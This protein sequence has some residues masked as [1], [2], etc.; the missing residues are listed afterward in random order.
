[1]LCMKYISPS[2]SV[3]P[4]PALLFLVSL[5][6]LVSSCPSPCQCK[7]LDGWNTLDCF[8]K[9]ITKLPSASDNIAAIILDKNDLSGLES[10]EFINAGLAHVRKIS[11]KFTNLS[12]IDED[13]FSG[14]NNLHELDLSHNSL[15]SLSRHQFPE[16][17]ELR[18]LDVSHNSLR[19]IHKD[20]FANLGV[21]VERI[22]LANNH[23]ISVP[24]TTFIPLTN[25][26]QLSL[27]DNP[28]HCDCKLGDLHSDLTH[29]N[30]IPDKATCTTPRTLFGRYWS[31]FHPSEFTCQPSVSLPHP[32]H[33][34]VQAGQLVPLHC[35]VKGNPTPTVTWKQDGS[36]LPRGSYDTYS[37]RQ[38]K[39][40]NGH[41][42]VI[43]SV[44]TIMNMSSLSLG[45]YSCLA[46]NSVGLE[47][48]D[49]NILFLDSTEGYAESENGQVILTIAICASLT[50]TTIITLT[51][52]LVCCIIRRKGI[53]SSSH[54][55]SFTTLEY[56]KKPA[57]DHDDFK[58]TWTNP[59]PKPPR[60]GA[61]DRMSCEDI[62][63]TLSRSSTRQTY[64]ASD[65]EYPDGDTSHLTG[66]G[67]EEATLPRGETGWTRCGHPP[68]L[69][70]DDS[71]TRDLFTPLSNRP[72]SR[73][74]VGTISTFDPIYGTVR[75]TLPPQY[76]HS[77][78]HP[79]QAI[80]L[81]CH[82]RP[83]Y[84]TLPRIPKSSQ[85]PALPLDYLGP[86]SSADG[87]SHSSISTLPLNKSTYHQ[88]NS[89]I[90]PPYSPPPP[91]T[92]IAINTIGLPSVEKSSSE[93]DYPTRT[94]TPQTHAAREGLLDTIPEQE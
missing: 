64:L 42:T 66:D 85:R 35:Q 71:Y 45:R 20:S 62:P 91:A 14:M 44:L 34:H 94:S 41:S 47:Q 6:T 37:I 73:S 16:L 28:W 27:G 24:W 61:Y 1:M 84:V 3:P 25:L 56:E 19:S 54:S 53:K 82:Q 9:N 22:N 55:R 88:C 46:E 13:L 11:M 86:R 7:W 69:G 63:G 50:I 80:P 26:K 43:F 36:T 75:R 70:V 72:G 79:Y 17:P 5:F 23:L 12:D 15:T 30:I 51:V 90:L 2:P 57:K 89:T 65:P 4:W 18:S 78:H 58:P 39:D 60:T 8:E 87:C 38:T 21:K 68:G 81:A 33:H 83:G 93:G 76:A 48:R 59:M 32:Q 49:L 92:I 40:G 67:H 10:Y 74:S 29:R 52:I 31:T 77:P